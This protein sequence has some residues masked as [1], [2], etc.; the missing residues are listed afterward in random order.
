M[1]VGAET[2]SSFPN[3]KEL[4]GALDL[5]IIVV[6]QPQI[7]IQPDLIILCRV[8]KGIMHSPS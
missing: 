7:G 5:A 4:A 1:S 6:V 8:I 3:P 2:A